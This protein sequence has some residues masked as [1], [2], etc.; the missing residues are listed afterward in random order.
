MQFDVSFDTSSPNLAGLTG[1]EQQAILDVA[2]AAATVWSWY[3]TAANVT[4]SLL[5]KVDDSFFS[6]NTLAQGGPTSFFSNGA[7]SGGETVYVAG[8]EVELTTGQDPNASTADLSLDLTTNSIRNLLY[9]KTDEY[10]AVP[11]GR[12]DAF[13]VFLHEIGHG[14][15]ILYA[16][17]DP[18]FPGTTPYDT[19]V[20]NGTF[21]GSNAEAAYQALFGS[22]TP[23]PLQSGS[24]S[25]LSES[26]NLGGDLM[27]PTLTTG[28]NVG[29]SAV[30]L[31]ILQD[32]G[33]PVRLAT[34]GD[35]VLHAVANVILHLGAGNDTGYAIATGSAV[36]GDDG[37][38]T[39]IGGPGSDVLYGGNGDDVLMGGGGNDALYGDAGNDIVRYSGL[40]SNYQITVLSTTS[41]RITDLRS[42]SPDGTDTVYNVEQAQ[43]DDGSITYL[44]VDRPPVVTTANLTA[45]RGQVIALS[46]LFSVS[47]PDGDTIQQ[48]QLWDATRDPSSGYFELNGNAFSAGTV[49]NVPAALLSQFYFVAGSVG[50]NLQIRAYDGKAWSVDDSVAWSAFTITVVDAPPVVTTANINEPANTA[51]PLSSL[52]SV[53]DPDGDTITR[54]ELWS[55]SSDPNSGHF[56]VNGVAKPAR[57]VIDITAAQL[58]QTSFVSGTVSNSLQ[59]RAFDGTAWS[60]PD[61]ATWSPFTVS[62][63]APPP[64]VTASDVT[65]AADHMVALSSLFGVTTPSGLP[66]IDYQIWETI[67]PGTTPDSANFSVP[68][69]GGA[70]SGSLLI[71]GV[72]QPTIYGPVDIPANQ[73]S[74]AS[75]LTGTG[76]GDYLLVRVFDGVNWSNT[77]PFTVS[78]SGTPNH[79]P[80]WTLGMRSSPT[81]SFNAPL[82]AFSAQRNQ[83]LVPWQFSFVFDADGDP[84]TLYEVEDMTTD[85]NSGHFVVNGVAQAAGT[86]LDLT[87]AQ[88][89]QTTFV[90]GTVGDTLQMRVSDG[91][92]WSATQTPNQFNFV[93]GDVAW[94]QLTISVPNTAPVVQTTNIAR[95]HN[96]TLALSSLF[97]VTDADG[98]TITKYQL[99]DST[100]DA[101][102]GHFVVNGV[103]QAANS[104]IEVTAAQLA[105]TSFVTGKV[106][107]NLQ[108]RAFDDANWSAADNAAWA[109][110]TVS[111]PNSAPVVTTANLTRFRSQTL[112]LS[113]LFTVSDAD[114]DAATRYQLWDGT[115]DSNSGH[116]VV[117]GTVQ[118]AGTIIDITAAD[119]ANTSFVTGSVGDTL[120]IRASDGVAWSAADNA[121]WAP[122]TI[123]V[124]DRPPVVTTSNVAAARSQTFAL[125]N[126]FSVTDADGDA[127]T[128]YQLWDATRDAVSGHFVVNGVAQPASSV[129][130]ISAANLTNTSFVAGSESDNLQI[131]AFDGTAWSAADNAFWA[132]FTVSVPEH[133]PVVTT[134]NVTKSHMQT[135]ALSSLFSVTDADGDPIT[136][137]QLWDA[138]RDP[139]SGHFVV[140]G[141]AQPASSVITIGAAD[142]ANTSFVTGTA[143]DNLQIRAFDGI[144]WSAA[145]NASWAPFTITVL[146]NRAPV[147]ATA[148]LTRTA[149]QN[150]ALS[151]LFTVT[152]ADN[153]VMTEYQLW[154]AT[155]DPASG[156]F[157]IGDAAQAAGTVIDISAAQLSQTTFVTG[158]PGTVDAL[159]IRA[160]DGIAWSAADNASWSPFH[161]A[162]S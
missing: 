76:F 68:Y 124:Q 9:F 114:G 15:G 144:T 43:W 122:F 8:T 143:G 35:D 21:T 97:S 61:S 73:L 39:L 107:D 153:D 23:L 127:I 95:T 71:N 30:D 116:F 6:G 49:L 45:Y 67:K 141:V 151:S 64:V 121:S 4:L 87:A 59:I 78:I 63:T 33:V 89:A 101:N 123:T 138:T 34:S 90:T 104:V 134:S 161:I 118:A 86:V 82:G 158:A 103:T 160:F 18:S 105:Q 146:A 120:Q 149:N 31:G 139:A 75:F 53:T 7:T 17:D 77:A 22:L 48:Y 147:V 110:F 13:S 65:L 94:G 81:G 66:I 108:I 54:Y 100:A 11:A 140:N 154:D 126:L 102:G 98:D 125:S 112:A 85:P 46:S 38:D 37:N 16:G 150:L 32:I 51:V 41:V 130:T 20:Q 135:F 117:N 42:G 58:A 142:L 96:Q 74:Q 28:T 129:I 155:R 84:I 2:N 109:P 19:F 26:S 79:R 136:Q 57:T 52:F 12:A 72:V 145:D 24:L 157:A 10:G 93:P 152:D 29:I 119:L 111:V 88:W 25:H 80:E 156:H 69:P 83:T 5:I 36:Y 55:G 91:K 14:L 162:V 133:A 128:Q 113:S 40:A 159:Q 47:D 27:S 60:A 1:A 148:D 3:L 137:C 70:S 50:D 56:V 131:R 132:P 44:P 115:R 62:I 99:L 92:N 106:G